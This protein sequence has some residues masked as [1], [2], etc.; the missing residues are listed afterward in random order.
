MI[1]ELSVLGLAPSAL[2]PELQI[3]RLAQVLPQLGSG[4]RTAEL[5]LGDET[6]GGSIDALD[7][8]TK[9]QLDQ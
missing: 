9:T 2:E 4:I 5:A 6:F 8:G 1:D 7:A 3:D